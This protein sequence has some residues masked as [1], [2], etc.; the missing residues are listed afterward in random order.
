MAR[1]YHWYMPKRLFDNP[2][3]AVSGIKHELVL[4]LVSDKSR[5]TRSIILDYSI[6]NDTLVSFGY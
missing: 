5:K 4:N 1:R 3:S 2:H 6:D